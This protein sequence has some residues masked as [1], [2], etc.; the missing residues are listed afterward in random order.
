MEKKITFGKKFR[1]FIK[2]NFRLLLAAIFLG[3]VIIFAIIGPIWLTDYYPTDLDFNNRNL[4]PS[5]DHPMGTDNSGRDLWSMVVYGSSV[6]LIVPVVV[7]ICATILGASLGLV[8]GFFPKVDQVVMR[9]LEAFGAI[10]S[11]LLIFVLGSAMGEGYPSL[12]TAMVLGTFGGICKMIRM[13][14]LSIRQKEFVEREVAMGAS[15]ARIMFMHVLPQCSS[16]LFLNFF[17]GVAGRMLNLS[18][19]SFL[20][21]GLPYGAYDWGSVASGGFGAILTKPYVCVPPMIL[22]AFTTYGLSMLGDGLRD[23]F[24]PKLK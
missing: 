5:W 11:M 14:T 12:I 8:C 24:D 16:W 1:V 21:Y 17:G 18:S 4:D 9:I 15:T 19:M 2:N 3:F 20:G 6:S 7:Q 22:I 10:P 23:Y 13:Q